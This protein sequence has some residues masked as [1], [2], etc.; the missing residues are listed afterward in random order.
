M[1]EREVSGI[2]FRFVISA[3]RGWCCRPRCGHKRDLGGNFR[4]VECEVYVTLPDRWSLRRWYIYVEFWSDLRDADTARKSLA[5]RD[6]AWKP[7]EDEPAQERSTSDS[8]PRGGGRGGPGPAW[9]GP[10]ATLLP[11]VASHLHCWQRIYLSFLQDP[12]FF[13]L[14]TRFIFL[15]ITFYHSSLL[16]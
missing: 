15:K 13:P 3:T 14:F 2:T 9:P 6:G 10:P 4:H 7:R 8:W 1:G 11:A 5:F 12:F 16:F